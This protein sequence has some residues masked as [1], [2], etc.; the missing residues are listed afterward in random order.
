MCYDTPAT[1]MTDMKREMTVQLVLLMP[2][3]KYKIN[4]PSWEIF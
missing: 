3:I 4:I 2:N 1:A